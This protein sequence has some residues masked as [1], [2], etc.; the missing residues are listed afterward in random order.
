MDL[1]SSR[2]PHA[3]RG[4]RRVSSRWWALLQDEAPTRSR[5]NGFVNLTATAHFSALEL[6]ARARS[7]RAGHPISGPET[8]AVS[9]TYDA[10]SIAGPVRHVSDDIWLV[11]FMQYTTSGTSTTR[12]AGSVTYVP[13]IICHPCVR[14]GPTRCGV[15]KGVWTSV[16]N[17][18]KRDS[19]GCIAGEC[20]DYGE[21][22]RLTGQVVNLRRPCT[23]VTG[24]IRVTAFVPAPLT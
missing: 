23:Q 12:P 10:P 21:T 1:D 22:H 3:T 6:N 11:S 8:P 19:A 14:H 9:A 18:A 4:G 7:G 13:R 15:P 17:R 5:P 16:D 20:C 2:A 24:Y